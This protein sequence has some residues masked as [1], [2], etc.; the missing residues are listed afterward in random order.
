MAHRVIR[1]IRPSLFLLLTLIALLPAPP[2]LNAEVNSPLHTTISLTKSM[3]ETS[4][5]YSFS[6]Y[7]TIYAA[8]TVTDIQAG[9][10]RADI[11]WVNASGTVN[12][13]SPVSF[14]IPSSTSK[15]TGPGT[16]SHT[17][18]TWFRLM[19]NGPVKSSMT[20]KQF[21]AEML[22]KWELR[23]SINDRSFN[24]AEFEIR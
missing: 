20:G 23:V 4:P 5:Q 7:D 9:Q 3:S 6:P 24:K 21:D 18:Y 1:P 14:S 13:S 16:Y 17:F 12:R 15:A 22:S 10:Y 19:K 11:S 8:I 2:G